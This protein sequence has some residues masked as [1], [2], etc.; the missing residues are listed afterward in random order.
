M[1]TSSSLLVLAASVCFFAVGCA[2]K[3]PEP[4]K[5]PPITYNAADF[6]PQGEFEMKLAPSNG[7]VSKRSAPEGSSVQPRLVSRERE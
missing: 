6:V 1:K 4:P 5:A 2:A 3:Q 7:L